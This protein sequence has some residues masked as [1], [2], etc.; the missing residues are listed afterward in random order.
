VAENHLATNIGTLPPR[1]LEAMILDP[2]EP[3]LLTDLINLE[4]ANIKALLA[5]ITPLLDFYVDN[6]IGLL[7]S[8]NHSLVQYFTHVVLHGIRSIFPPPAITGHSIGD[9]ISV[10]KLLAGNSIW[11]VRKEILG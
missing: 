11:A 4:T 6:Y 1:P 2:V 5:K 3:G 8:T 9:R 10:K 7:H